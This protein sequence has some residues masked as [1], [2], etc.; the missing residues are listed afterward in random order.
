MIGRLL[1]GKTLGLDSDEYRVHRVAD[2]LFPKEWMDQ[3]SKKV[4][5]KTNREVSYEVST[6]RVIRRIDSPSY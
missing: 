6:S 5:G 1:G 2:T 4:E 3:P